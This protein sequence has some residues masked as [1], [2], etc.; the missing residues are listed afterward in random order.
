MPSLRNL[1]NISYYDS[2]GKQLCYVDSNEANRKV[3]ADD[4]ELFCV[5]CGKVKG[6]GP[7][8]VRSNHLIALRQ[9]AVEIEDD[10][11]L[12]GRPESASALTVRD[13]KRNV[14]ITEGFPGDAADAAQVSSSRRRIKFWGWASVHN[15]RTVTIAPAS[16]SS[17]GTVDSAESNP[18][19]R[20]R[21]PRR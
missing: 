12:K 11:Q 16:A 14:G 17:R 9:L 19:R 2:T 5:S 18:G 15:C 3:A 20:T 8:L 6:E 13:M 10:D 21:R 1:R 4:H 7:C